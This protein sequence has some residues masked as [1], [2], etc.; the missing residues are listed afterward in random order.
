MANA[1]I[2]IKK[3]KDA[4]QQLNELVQR[5]EYLLIIHYSCESFY[6]ITDGRSPRIT[7]IAVRYYRT[8]QTISFSIHKVAEKK[9]N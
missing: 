6:N 1:K 2:R 4:L 3:R 8:G 5:D 7:S 9:V